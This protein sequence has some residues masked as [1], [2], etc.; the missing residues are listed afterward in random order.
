MDNA[1]YQIY[2]SVWILYTEFYQELFSNCRKNDINWTELLPNVTH[3]IPC[4][5]CG[6]MD[7]WT[8]YSAVQYCR[9]RFKKLVIQ[10]KMV[11]N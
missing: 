2:T 3:P 10:S 5:Y 7:H 1:P 4:L 6:L 8:N 9:G 11:N